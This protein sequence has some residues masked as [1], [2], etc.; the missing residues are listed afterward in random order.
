[1]HRVAALLTPRP[2]RFLVLNHP[3]AALNSTVIEPLSELLSMAAGELPGHPDH[4]LL[5]PQ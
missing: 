3:E 5:R 2:P 4:P 1:M